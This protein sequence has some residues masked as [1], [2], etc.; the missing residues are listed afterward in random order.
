MCSVCNPGAKEKKEIKASNPEIPSIYVGETARSIKERIEEH[1]QAYK[2]RNQDSH[3]MKHQLLHHQGAEP[4][5]TVRVVDYKKTALTRQL[6]EA[7]RIRR[8]GGEGAVLN[9]KGEFNRS[10]IPR[11]VVEETDPE[12]IEKLEEQRAQEVRKYLDKEQS[13]WEKEKIM[14]RDQQ[15]LGSR[16]KFNIDTKDKKRAATNLKEQPRKKLKRRKYTIIG[17]DWGT[18]S[19]NLNIDKEEEQ[20]EPQK[21]PPP[22]SSPPP[23]LTQ[24]PKPSPPQVTQL[25]NSTQIAPRNPDDSS[26]TLESFEQGFPPVQVAPSEEQLHAGHLGEVTKGWDSDLTPSQATPSEGKHQKLAG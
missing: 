7:V 25:P 14:L 26:Q 23:I 18:G 3:I 10:R 11:L 15:H 22:T 5:F 1:H 19:S 21:E 4:E 20:P 2:S 16:S 8:R 9:S 17:E 13:K 12:E 24:S 6:G